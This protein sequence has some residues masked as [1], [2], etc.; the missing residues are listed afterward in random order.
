MIDPG[1]QSAIVGVVALG[2][3]YLGKL[4]VCY[5]RLKLNKNNNR[6]LFYRPVCSQH[7]E[8]LNIIR[9][10]KNHYDE[11]RQIELYSKAIK[12]ANGQD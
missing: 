1:V 3:A 12:R 10:L 4:S 5:L 6:R 9:E 11:E 7:D 8:L 2:V